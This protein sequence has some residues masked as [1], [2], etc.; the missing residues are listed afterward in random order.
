[1]HGHECKIAFRHRAI[2]AVEIV[3]YEL[4]EISA[5]APLSK[6]LEVDLWRGHDKPAE[7]YYGNQDTQGSLPG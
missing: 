3:R 1:M 5:E 7:G 4:E 6:A 2:N